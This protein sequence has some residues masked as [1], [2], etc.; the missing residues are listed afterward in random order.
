MLRRLVHRLTRYGGDVPVVRGAIEKVFPEHWSFLLGEAALY[1]FAILVGTGI[2]LALFFSP[3]PELVVYEGSYEPLRGAEMSRAYRSTLEL[4]FDVRAGLLVRQVHHWAALVFVAAIVG[5]LLRVLLTGA[6]RRPRELNW[7]VGVSLLFLALATGYAGYSMLDDVLSHVGLQIGHAATSSV[8]VVGT[9]MAHVM[10]GGEQPGGEMIPRLYWA[11]VLVFPL[12]LAGLV[13]LHMTILL[14]QK[15]T[16]FPGP[17]KRH[18]NVVG[19]RLWPRYTFETLGLFFALAALLVLLG[20]LV[21][22]NPIW[23]YGPQA[24]GAASSGLQ[25]DW[26]WAWLTGGLVLMPGWDLTLFGYTVP[27]QFFPGPLLVAATIVLLYA[28][29]YIAGSRADDLPGGR[30]LLE[31][32]RERPVLTAVTAG[33]VA[34]YGVLTVA[35]SSDVL[36]LR[37][38]TGIEP[39]VWAFR[40]LVLALPPA[41]GLVAYRA[42]RRLERTRAPRLLDMPLRD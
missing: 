4:S 34:F 25:P 10:F 31:R 41:V 40:A 30:H 14:L 3:S 38:G 33:V 39:V 28:V 9:W 36:A 21:Q 37:L 24:P 2:Y 17:G 8:P 20:G 7:M 22:I 15:H 5:H 1:S 35:A 11:H 27:G 18:D 12:L 26:Y 29:P 6:F 23:L 32:P 42:A 16:Q 13:G 19:T